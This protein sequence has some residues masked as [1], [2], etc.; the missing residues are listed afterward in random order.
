MSNG[1]NVKSQVPEIRLKENGDIEVIVRVSGF[2]YGTDAEITGY[3]TQTNGV[4]I[5]F[6]DKQNI[7]PQAAGEW[8]DLQ[9]TVKSTKL[10]P[11]EGIRVIT[12][13]AALWPTELADKTAEF[14]AEQAKQG[15]QPGQEGFRAVWR[16]NGGPGYGYGAN[17]PGASG[18]ASTTPPAP[19]PPAPPATAPGS[20]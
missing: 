2:M 15:Q 3:I 12:R 4:L 10:V 17:A 8:K 5:P 14:Q 20:P 16:V 13:V 6:F 18:K 1:S 7:P 11:R 19:T 9:V